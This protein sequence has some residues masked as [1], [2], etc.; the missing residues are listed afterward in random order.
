MTAMATAKV[1]NMEGA[2][3]GTVDLKD[4]VFSAEM[5]PT[6]VHDVT[7]ALQAAKRQ[8]NAETKTRKEVRGGGRKPY[9]QKGTGNARHGSIREP[10][11]RGGGT[12]F[13]PHK[14]SYR[15]NVPASFKRK[16]LCCALS[17]RLR[18]ESLLVLDNLACDAPKT[19]RV[20]E[21]AQKLPLPN[22]RTLIVTAE[23]D[24][25]VVLSARNLQRV[26][27]QTAANVNALDVLRAA[28]V[29]VVQDALK[30]LEERLS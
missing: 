20:A 5:N 8:G 14:R 27:V 16:A 21:M 26:D 24:H 1:Y 30:T 4:A 2:E 6:L 13:G 23:A 15:K 25:N 3:V 22:K 18:E 9:R 19:K 11:M 12:V 7:V 29:V 17:D 28:R 10:Q